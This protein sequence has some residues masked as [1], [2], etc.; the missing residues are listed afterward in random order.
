MAQ[1]PQ[2]VDCRVD[3]FTG[4]QLGWSLESRVVMENFSA[5]KSLMGYRECLE[6]PVENSNFGYKCSLARLKKGGSTWDSRGKR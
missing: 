1:A 4:S 3:R 2:I 6:N 5:P